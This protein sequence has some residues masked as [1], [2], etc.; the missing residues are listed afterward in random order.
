MAD[1]DKAISDFST[2]LSTVTGLQTL[3]RLDHIEHKVDLVMEMLGAAKRTADQESLRIQKLLEILCIRS[4]DEIKRDRLVGAGGQGL[5]FE[6]KFNRKKVGIKVIKSRTG[7]PL[8]HR[9][10][11][12]E[13]ELMLMK[14]AVDPSV[15]TLYGCFH[16]TFETLIVLDLAIR[17]LDA[18]LDETEKFPHIPL[19]LNIAWVMDIAS[20]VQ[21]LHEKRIRHKDIKAQNML[22]F[23]S[24]GKCL[25]LKI[26]DFGLA[27]ETLTAGT[28]NTSTAGTLVFCAPEYVK[29]N[30]YSPWLAMC[31]L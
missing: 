9:E 5:V 24:T 17:S 30:I 13:N 22:V 11:A 3:G 10:E 12:I 6:G 7:M 27:R 20:A 28:S 8:S 15:L 19:S 1:L 14:A 16:D 2:I 4:I 31:I 29:D 23:Q 26:G 21:S 18:I 25:D